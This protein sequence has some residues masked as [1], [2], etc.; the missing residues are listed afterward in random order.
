MKVMRDKQGKKIKR[1]S[2][3]IEHQIRSD[4]A[5]RILVLLVTLYWL[6]NLSFSYQANTEGMV[7][8]GST[9]SL[10]SGDRFWTSVLP[11]QSG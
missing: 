9:E 4:E 8:R 11:L 1:K 7:V 10:L 2:F 5:S 3:P 6:L